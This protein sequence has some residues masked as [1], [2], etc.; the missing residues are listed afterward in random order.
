MAFVAEE[1]GVP[2]VHARRICTG[3]SHRSAT[4]LAIVPPRA[5]DPRGAAGDPAHAHREG[6]RGR[7]D[8]GAARRR[9][10]AADHRAHVPRPRAARLLRPAHDAR[11]SGRSSAGSLASRRARGGEPRGAR[12]P[13]ALR[14]RAGVEVLGRSASGS[15][16][17]SASTRAAT[18]RAETTALLGIPPNAFVVG[19]VGRMTAVKRTDDVLHALQRLVDGGV[20]AYLCL[21]GDGPDRDARSSSYAHELGVTQRL[22]LPRLPGRRRPFYARFDALLLPSANE[23]TPVSAIEALAAG[24][25]VVA[26]RV[27]GVPDVV[28]RRRRRIPRRGRRRRRA[29]RSSRRARRRP[30]T[31]RARMG[32]DGRARVVERY[33]VDRLVDD[34]DRLYR[35]RCSP[36]GRRLE[37]AIAASWASR[38]GAAGTRPTTASS[39]RP[40]VIEPRL[41]AG[42][43]GSSLTRNQS[44]MSMR[45]FFRAI[46][47]ACFRYSACFAQDDAEDRLVGRVRLVAVLGDPEVLRAV[48]LRR[49]RASRML[50]FPSCDR[51]GCLAASAMYEGA[52]LPASVVR[53][54]RVGVEALH[55]R[56][57]SRP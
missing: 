46:A 29:R 53:V 27:G 19:W 55:A 35:A 12:R 54:V 13:R 1:L 33:A 50:M 48:Q 39:C 21:V 51:G 2:I 41:P 9:R 49:P 3:R 38:A 5:A 26:T 11:S 44:I 15:S 16:S 18:A 22:P 4:S 20:D 45:G 30:R 31:S 52:S 24:R 32:A 57:S 34:I 17:T 6:G 47:N 56:P 37:P 14:C 36:R 23:G 7:P 10:A 8:R 43:L 40:I 28:A 42:E 25:P